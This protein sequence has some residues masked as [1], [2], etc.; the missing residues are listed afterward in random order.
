MKKRYVILAGLIAL[1]LAFF[2]GRYTTP[3]E[4]QIK[5]VEKIVEK[6]KIVEVVV[7]EYIKEAKTDIK[8]DVVKTK[9]TTT[10]PDGTVTVVETEHL[11]EDT[12]IDEKEVKTEIKVVEVEK[13]IEKEKIVERL[14]STDRP[15]WKVSVLGGV[16]VDGI[17]LSKGYLQPWVVGANVERRIVG[18]F[19][20]GVWGQSNLSAGISVGF[21]F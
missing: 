13:I 8:L 7:K 12:K 1:I 11:K 16:Q 14:V 2:A 3:V 21:E 18:P 15:D 20:V 6:E 5:E 17:E 4:V 10:K 9:T 19:S